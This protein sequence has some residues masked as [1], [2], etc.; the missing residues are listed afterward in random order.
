MKYLK[1]ILTEPLKSNER[2]G[3]RVD[4]NKNPAPISVITNQLDTA[5]LN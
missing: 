4:K 1:I 2:F 3:K 5:N